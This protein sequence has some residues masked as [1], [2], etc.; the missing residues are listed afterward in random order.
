[1]VLITPYRAVSME[2]FLFRLLHLVRCLRPVTCFLVQELLLTELT[3]PV[4]FLHHTQLDRIW[5]RWQQAELGKRLTEYSGRAA[6]NS[7]LEASLTD[8]ISMG[9]LA[10]DISVV[11]IMDTESGML[12]YRY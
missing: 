2:T 4:F 7:T 6:T 8:M 3:N 12:C 5:W 11:E 10:P 9:G 1:M